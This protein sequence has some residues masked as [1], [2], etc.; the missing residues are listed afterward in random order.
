MQNRRYSINIHSLNQWINEG[1]LVDTMRF[2]NITFMKISVLLFQEWINNL[3]CW[4]KRMP[5][6]YL[7]LVGSKGVRQTQTRN[8]GS[9]SFVS[10]IS[11]DMGALNFVGVPFGTPLPQV[12]RW[13]CSPQRFPQDSPTS[14]LPSPSDKI[15]GAVRLLHT[16]PAT[17]NQV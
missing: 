10:F 8:M 9:I 13:H 16:L 7:S 6:F 17:F 15:E 3:L 2:C 14:C 5:I 11:S 12:E 1:P 4:G